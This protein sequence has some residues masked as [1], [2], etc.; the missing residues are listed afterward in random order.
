MPTPEFKTVVLRA[1]Q[2]FKGKN[3]ALLPTVM[4]QYKH[5]VA[6]LQRRG[7]WNPELARLES[8]PF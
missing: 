8:P 5:V 1:M 7:V 2:I 4:L 6:N 3:K